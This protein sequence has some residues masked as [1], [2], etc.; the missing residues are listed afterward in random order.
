MGV[1]LLAELKRRRVFRA[2]LGYAIVA[3]AVLQVIE[4]IIHGLQLPDWTLSFVVVAIG[5]GFPVAL[6][7]AWV[8]DVSASG[9]ERT[10]PVPTEAGSQ[11]S[12]ALFALL[13]AGVALVG[14]AVVGWHFAFRPAARRAAPAASLPAAPSV[15]VLPFVNMSREKDDDY[16]SDGITEEVINALANVEGVRVVSRTSAFAFKGK[17]LSVRKIGEELAVATVLEGSVRR[18]GN[19]VRIVAQLIN[20]ADG[21]HLWSKTYDR[22]LENVFAVEDELARSI[23]EAL[24][25]RLLKQGAPLVGQATSSTEA[26]DLYL[27]GR[28]FWNKRTADDLKRASAL[29]RQALDVDAGYALAHAGLADSYALLAEYS[30]ARPEEVLPQASEHARK[31]LELDPALAEPHATLGLIAMSGYD[32]PAAER[33]FQRAIE[34]RSAYPTAHHW[35]ALLL[36]GLGRSAEARAE[37]ERALQLDPASVIVNNM[38]GVVSYL[39]RDYERA[40]E[41]FRRTLELE[42]A[43]ATA[44]AFLACAYLGAGKNPEALAQLVPLSDTESEHTALRAWVLWTAGEREAA[45]RLAR[46]LV[47][48]SGPGQLRLGIQAALHGLLGDRDR[49][50][51]LLDRAYAEKDWSLRDLKVSP[52]WDPLR[53]DPRFPNL[54]KKLKLDSLAPTSLPGAR[55]AP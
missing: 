22:T 46:E 52:V 19:D 49:A 10:Q 39:A 27:R 5:V 11:P 30:P 14:V 48:R 16:F 55:G 37:A 18:Q 6:A 47:A 54:L 12:P 34:L 4:P 7:L 51:A 24:R 33:E 9:I 8:F 36:S 20:A 40:I 38:Q 13:A 17:N 23:T 26:H 21:Y 31:A 50:F 29:F 25:P 43:F 41:S 2:L 44:R 28:H 53:G 15:A 35:Y 42:P 32:W 1:P 45:Q 3:F